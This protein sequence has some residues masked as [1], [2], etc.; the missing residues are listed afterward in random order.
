M[1]MQSE[2]HTMKVRITPVYLQLFNN[3]GEYIVEQLCSL[4]TEP[5]HTCLGN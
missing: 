1:G 2:I 3:L 5:S 4:P